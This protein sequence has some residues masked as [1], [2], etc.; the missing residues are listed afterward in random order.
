MTAE[1]SLLIAFELHS[2]E[3]IARALDGGADA[4]APIRRKPPIEWL[5]E[6]YTRSDRFPACVRLLLERGATL[7]DAALAPVLLN[8]SD[9]ITEAVRSDAALLSRRTSMACAFTPLDGATPLHV[10]AEYGHLDAARA[11]LELG[12]DPNARAAFD[13]DGLNAQ[14]PLFHTVSSH[15]NRSAPIMRLLL[16]SGARSDVALR[17]LT[18]GRGFE[19]ETTLFDVTPVS[20]AQ[21]GLLPQIHRNETEIADNVRALLESAGRM[22]RIRNVPNRY[23]RG[24]S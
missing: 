13:E 19:W 24:A 6:M 11:L 16:A 22:A 15:D 3:Q 20:Y 5:L 18:W 12:A 23:L 4:A 1:E 8:D 21:F 9:G 7:P 14:T 2:P 10:A 17:G